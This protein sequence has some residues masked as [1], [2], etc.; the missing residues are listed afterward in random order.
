MFE[1]RSWDNSRQCL[2]HLSRGESAKRVYTFRETQ[3]LL[4][5]QQEKIGRQ[6]V[7][8]LPTSVEL[9]RCLS[10]SYHA[11]TIHQIPVHIVLDW[12]DVRRAIPSPKIKCCRC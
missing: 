2:V 7:Q 9:L 8:T 10:V 12:V 3:H 4:W 5:L 11:N 6:N 1:S